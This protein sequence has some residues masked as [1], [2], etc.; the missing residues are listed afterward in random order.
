MLKARLLPPGRN[1]LLSRTV[2]RAL[3]ELIPDPLPERAE[4]GNDLQ[5]RAARLTAIAGLIESAE[6]IPEWR[7]AQ[8]R[9]YRPIR[10]AFLG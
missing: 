2:A 4:E 1:F 8:L 6:N 10:P 7:P 9:T 5:L 3:V